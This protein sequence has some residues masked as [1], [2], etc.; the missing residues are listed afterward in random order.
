MGGGALGLGG[1][2][3]GD[4]WGLGGREVLVAAMGRLIGSS[5]IERGFACLLDHPSLKESLLEIV[6]NNSQ[7]DQKVGLN[8]VSVIVHFALF[9]ISSKVT[10]PK[11]PQNIRNNPR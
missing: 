3:R 6:E 4:G 10:F 8:S 9:E 1:E 2:G 11:T 7:I 5:Y